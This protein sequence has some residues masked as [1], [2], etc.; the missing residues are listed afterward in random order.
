MS[1]SCRVPQDGHCHVRVFKLRSARRYPHAEHVLDDGY[2]R[3]TVI[4][5]RPYLAALY[6]IMA[7][8][9]APPAVR[10][11]LGQRAVADHVLHGQVLDRDH[12]MV[13]DQAGAGL[14][15]EIGA[16]G[17]DLA[18]RPGDL[19]LGLGP[20]RGPAL[21][22]GQAPLVAGQVPFPAGQ[23]ARVGDL[24]AA[25]VTAKSL[26][27]RSTP[28]ALPVAGSCSGSAAS[29]A[30]ETYQRPHGSRETVTVDGSIDAGSMS[31]HDQANASGVSILAR[32]S[33]PSRYRNPDRVNSADCRPVR[34]LIPRVACAAG[35]EVGVRDLLVPDRL[36]KRDRG[37]L[38]QPR[39]F[40]GGFHSSQVG[41]RL[42]EVRLHL[43]AAVIPG[44]PPR[45]R[46]VPHDAD[47]S[48][49]AVQR[50]GLLRCRIRP[51]LIRRP[52][53]HQA[54]LA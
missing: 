21:A 53:N 12:V 50:A 6:S 24:L 18:V 36:L 13:A 42:G 23:A 45:K 28:T 29:T 51:A 39:Q 46:P 37:H 15:E 31:G 20:V 27:P 8:E 25:E 43:L 5:R 7:P 34:D 2:H 11:R 54:Y 1:R 40:P 48:E 22:A 47:A 49:R 33:A 19:G 38:V 26:M 16:G 3:S 10:D 35:E 17:A 9:G 32:N 44:V 14:V 52:H 30:K 41:V 4:T